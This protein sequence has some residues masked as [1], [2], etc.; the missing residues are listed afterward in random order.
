MNT[1]PAPNTQRKYAFS[2]DLLECFSGKKFT[3]KKIDCWCTGDR[4][5]RFLATVKLD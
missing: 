5:C 1:Q 4:A 2:W 3:V